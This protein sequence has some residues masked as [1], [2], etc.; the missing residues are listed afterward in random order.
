MS[1]NRRDPWFYQFGI[2]RLGFDHVVINTHA[3]AAH[4]HHRPDDHCR[5]PNAAGPDHLRA[6]GPRHFRA[7]DNLRL[8]AGGDDQHP[9]GPRDGC[10]GHLPVLGRPAHHPAGCASRLQPP[11]DT[12]ADPERVGPERDAPAAVPGGLHRRAPPLLH[13]PWYSVPA[14]IAGAHPSLQPPPAPAPSWP[15]WPAPVLAAPPAPFAPAAAP[16][17]PHWPAPAPAAPTAPPAPVQLPPPPPSSRLGQSTPGG[18]PIQ[19]VRF[20]PS[21]SPIPAWLTGT[22]PPPVY[23]EAGDPPVPTLQS[24][25]SSGSA[26][27]YDG[28]PTIDRAPSSSLLR[29]A[30]PVG[31]GAPTQKPPRFAK[32]DFATY[33]LGAL[34]RALPPSFW[35][36]DPREPPG[37]ARPPSLHLHGAGLRRPFPGPGMPCV[38]CDGATAGR[39][40]CRWTSGSHPRGRGASGTPGSLVGHVLRPRVRAPRGG[41]PAGVTVP[42]RW[43]ATRA[44]FRAGSAC[45]SFCGTPRRDRG[46]PVPPAHL[47]RATRASPP[48]VVLQLRRALHARPCL[49]ATLLPGGCRLHSGG[50]RRRRPGRPSCRE[51][52]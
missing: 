29:T 40:L 49:P 51:G 45:A 11:G 46:A 48:R 16:Q 35:A 41:H 13:L 3:A 9:A 44:G 30:E 20:P 24:G 17:W 7:A 1:I 32:I 36:P 14:A 23:T 12:L 37:G 21:P 42:D 33:D 5:V 43:V 39:P 50:R 38:G 8:H 15:Q 22:S 4:H 25:A 31:H 2:Q 10:P 18:L 28:L 26:G 47:S 34:P 19:Q 52:V 27:A 6:A